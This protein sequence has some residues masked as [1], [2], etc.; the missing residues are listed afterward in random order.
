MMKALLLV[1]AL[2]L[3]VV[4]ATNYVGF[5]VVRAYLENEKQIAEVNTW[6]LDVWTRESTLGV[7]WNDILIHFYVF[8]STSL[9]A[10][11]HGSE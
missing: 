4:S 2:C 7:G 8:L 11:R 1:L 6:G 10:L 3:T 5:K 9:T